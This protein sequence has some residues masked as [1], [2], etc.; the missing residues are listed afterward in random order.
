MK[1]NKVDPI[2]VRLRNTKKDP[3]MAVVVYNLMSSDGE[4]IATK[5]VEIDI[6]GYTRSL[7][8]VILDEFSK[9][10]ESNDNINTSHELYEDMENPK[11]KEEKMGKIDKE[12]R[13]ASLNLP[14][15][16]KEAYEKLQSK[17]LK[18]SGGS[19]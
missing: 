6:T 13:N 8:K 4:A 18:G 7:L 3:I 17:E 15:N 19:K 16:I 14:P 5:R 11:Q 12:L 2:E 9:T 10:I 1:I